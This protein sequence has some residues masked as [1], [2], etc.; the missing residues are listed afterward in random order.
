[1]RRLLQHGPYPLGVGL[2]AAAAF[3]CPLWWLG[4]AVIGVGLVWAHY[5]V[6][7]VEEPKD[8]DTSSAPRRL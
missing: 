2:V 3:L 6:V 4:F 1:M 7:D 5:D 8:A